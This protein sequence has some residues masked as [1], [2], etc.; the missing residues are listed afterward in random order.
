MEVKAKVTIRGAKIFKGTI[1]GKDMDSGKIFTDVDLKGETSWGVCTQELKCS[2]SAMV[3]EI[4]HNP[5]PFIAEIDIL[6]ESNGKVTSQ[7]VTKIKPMQR[8]A[9]PASAAKAA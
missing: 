5:F 3:K 2:D 7:L 9:A 4:A 1:D 8:E 6:M